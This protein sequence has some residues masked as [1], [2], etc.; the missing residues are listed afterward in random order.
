MDVAREIE[1]TEEHVNPVVRPL[2]ATFSPTVAGMAGPAC[3]GPASAT[4]PV[5][6]A[7]RERM[8]PVVSTVPVTI[9]AIAASTLVPVV[10]RFTN[11]ERFPTVVVPVLEQLAS[12]KPGCVMASPILAES[13]R[14]RT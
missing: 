6:V 3:G 13:L 5:A 12:I 10:A 8:L 11:W 7:P 14:A 1:L 4:L 2:F 9:W